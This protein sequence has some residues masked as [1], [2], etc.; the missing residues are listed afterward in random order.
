MKKLRA[1][2]SK[3]KAVSEFASDGYQYMKDAAPSERI[4]FGVTD[5]V[6]LEC[7][8]T[9]DYHRIEKGISLRVPK[10]PFG[11][12]VANRI[13][14]NLLAFDGIESTDEGGRE[15]VR[16]SVE[17]LEALN[18]WNRE[19][20]RDSRLDFELATPRSGHDVDNVSRF[21]GSRSSVRS[22]DRTR[23]IPAEILNNAIA[24]AANSPSVCNRQSWRAHLYTDPVDVLNV[25]KLQNGNSAFRD[26]V[27][28]VAVVTVDRRLFSGIEER[29]QRWVDG[30]LFAMSLVWGLHALGLSSCMLNWSVNADRSRALREE[31]N[32]PAV[33]DIIVMIAIGYADEGAKRAR[34]SRRPLEGIA[35]F[36]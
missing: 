13:Q 7:T 36:H 29:N 11:E 30:G 23:E 32:I 21:F 4:A 10:R 26:E 28:C 24:L 19:G 20:E 8:L 12:A 27:P 18:L 15:F 14:H 35:R 1:F 2:A 5:P 3:L 34:S 6:H 9:K 17:A 31:G 25:L 33:E 16:Y 22:F